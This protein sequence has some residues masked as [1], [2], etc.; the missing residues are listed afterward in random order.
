[1]DV[2]FEDHWA[3]VTFLDDGRLLHTAKAD[4]AQ[5]WSLYAWPD[6][7]SA[8]QAYQLDQVEWGDWYDSPT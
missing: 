8:Q 5:R 3:I 4:G 2:I 6:F 1:M 7:E